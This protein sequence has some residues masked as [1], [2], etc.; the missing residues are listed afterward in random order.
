MEFFQT[1]NP[2]GSWWNGLILLADIVVAIIGSLTYKKTKSRQ[3]RNSL[4][5]IYTSLGLLGTFGAI[6]TSLAGIADS[7]AIDTASKVGKAIE[8]ISAL[9]GDLDLK[10]IISDLIPAFS[11]SI[12]GL[13]FAIVS[14]IRTKLDYAKEDSELEKKLKFSNTE[15]LLEN[16]GENLIATKELIAIDIEANSKNN[17][18][19]KESIQ[20][21]SKIFSE[22][23]NTFVQQMEETFTAMK[24][25]IGERVNAFGEEQFKQSKLVLEEITAKLYDETKEITSTHSESVKKISSSIE[26]AVSDLKTNTVSQID[27]LA[28]AQQEKLL[29]IAEDN[30]KHNMDQLAIQKESIEKQNEFNSSLVNQMSTTISGS[31]DSIISSIREQCSVLQTAIAKDVEML[32]KSFDFIDRKSS[33]IVSNYQQSAEAFRQ[34]VQNSHDINSSFQKSVSAID[35]TLKAAEKTNKGIDKVIETIDSKETNIEAVIMRI[36]GMSKAIVTLQRLEAS[37]SKIS[38]K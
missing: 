21:Q 27:A 15:E 8:E 28:S 12:Y 19:L 29:K 37:I 4:P 31:M 26:A 6:C 23:V 9:T 30:L 7:H 17:E 18:E 36:E 38:G 32:N 14:T 1:L 5:G 2:I 22:F 33:D 10:R 34:A 24:A 16:I 35:N 11:T 13:L 25:T 3:L 20:A